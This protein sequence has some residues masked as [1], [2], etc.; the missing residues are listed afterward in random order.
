ML[1]TCKNI[2]VMKWANVVV[3]L[4]C[5]RPV[6]MP[7]SQPSRLY[8]IV[9]LSMI[10]VNCDTFNNFRKSLA[11]LYASIVVML[12]SSCDRP[13]KTP[14]L[15]PSSLCCSMGLPMI[16]FCSLTSRTPTPHHRSAKTDSY[17]RMKVSKTACLLQICDFFYQL[18]LDVAE[19]N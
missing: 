10:A 5:N 2:L 6:R 7:L 13:V 4:S 14:H 19:K 8:Y 11:M 3:M 15:Q 16:D 18:R 9:E 1:N 12:L 17:Q